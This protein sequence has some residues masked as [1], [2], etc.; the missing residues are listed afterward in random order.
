MSSKFNPASR[1]RKP[2][3]QCKKSKPNPDSPSIK[4]RVGSLAGQWLLVSWKW[5]PAVA[6]PDWFFDVTRYVEV[7]A[8][9]NFLLT[10]TYPGGY[11]ASISFVW[12][13]ID[14]VWFASCDVLLNFNI[15]AT[16]TGESFEYRGTYP[17]SIPAYSIPTVQ[18]GGNPPTTLTLSVTS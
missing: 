3:P 5:R 6:T 10:A 7:N 14:Q 1:T 2:P 9:N 18:V 11:E 13:H 16:T 15:I 4:T 12:N 8:F 17:F